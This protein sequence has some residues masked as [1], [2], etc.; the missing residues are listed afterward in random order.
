MLVLTSCNQEDNVITNRDQLL[1]KTESKKN[2][3]LYS[4][5]NILIIKSENSVD[6]F[7]KFNSRI[8]DS[9]F[10][11]E[12]I[13][14][15]LIKKLDFS[16]YEYKK[17]FVTRIKEGVAEKGVNFAGHFCF[18][19]WGCGSPC[20]LSAVVDLNTGIVYNG[21][22]SEIGYE[23]RKNSKLMIVNPPDSSRWFNKNVLWQQPSQY[24]WTGTKF[25]KL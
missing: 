6:T 17:R 20:K 23:F 9:L 13:E 21:L 5:N 22:S 10:Y 1:S 8:N 11:K 14:I 7:L 25:V 24:V 2:D 3:T 16:E 19:Y 4:D 18:V 15:K 12:P